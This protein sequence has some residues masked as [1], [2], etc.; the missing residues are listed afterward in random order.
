MQTNKKPRIIGAVLTTALL[1]TTGVACSG[2]DSDAKSDGS[3]ASPAKALTA[4]F[5][6]TTDAKSAKVDMTM[7]MPFANGGGDMD[8]SGVVGWEPSVMDV[9]LTGSSLGDEPGTPDKSRTVQR[10]GVMYMD[11][12]STAASGMEGKRWLKMD[13]KAVA[14]YAEETKDPTPRTMLD[15]SLENTNQD[16]AQQLALLLESPNLK[17]VGTQKID[18]AEAEHYKGKLT[19]AEMLKTNDALADLDKEERD[20]LLKNMKKAGVKGY[21]IEAWVNGD[22]LPVRM[23][24]K[25]Q[26]E[27][28][29]IDIS[30]K[31]S[32]YGTEVKAEVPKASETLDL[33]E[34]IKK[35]DKED[36]A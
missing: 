33:L 11:M 34:T 3:S 19:V 31:Y 17:H 23:D 13:T 32:D 16:P 5:K 18:G 35:L 6:K 29:V 27:R 7:R 20:E 21:D 12:G 36:P 14:E 26:V 8:M 24:V 22:D 10:D 2:G 30:T 9:T 25:T 1:C 4:A 28:G 15:I